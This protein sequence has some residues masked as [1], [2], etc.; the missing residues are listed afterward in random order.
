MKVIKEELI[1]F[2]KAMEDNNSNMKKID[3]ADTVVAVNP[4]YG[5]ALADEE[6]AKEAVEKVMKATAKATDG[7]TPKDPDTGKPLEKN[8][9]SKQ[10]K[11][12]DDE[13]E[14]D[15]SLDEAKGNVEALPDDVYTLVY[16]LIFHGNAASNTH[17]VPL[18]QEHR[19]SADKAYNRLDGYDI[20]AQI[21]NDEKQ[22]AEYIKKIAKRLGLETYEKKV[23]GGLKNG[24]YVLAVKIPDDIAE[25]SAEAF[26]KKNG[27]DKDDIRDTVRKKAKNPGKKKTSKKAIKESWEDFDSYEEIIDKYMLPNGEGDTLA[28][29]AVTAVNKLVYKWFNDGDVYDNT[30]RLEGWANDLSSYANWLY[31]YVDGTQDILDRITEARSREDYE[32][33]LKALCDEVLD[34]ELLTELAKAEKQDSIYEAEGPFK[35]EWHDDDDEEFDEGLKKGMNEAK[36]CKGKKCESKEILTLDD[37]DMDTKL[38]R[39]GSR[40]DRPLRSCDTV[41]D[42]LQ[43]LGGGMDDESSIE[44]STLDELNRYLK[45]YGFKPIG[46]KNESKKCNE[47]GESKNPK[48]EAEDKAYTELKNGLIPYLGY[49]EQLAKQFGISKDDA[50]Q[51]F[52][53]AVTRKTYGESK[54]CTGK[55]CGRDAINR[56]LVESWRGEEVLDDLIDRAK[57]W[58]DSG[59][60]DIEEAVERAIDDGL[61]YTQ[62]VIDLAD[63]YGVIDE[64]ELR[65]KM[66]DDVF[67][68]VYEAVKDYRSD[69]DEDEEVDESKKCEDGKCADK[70][71]PTVEALDSQEKFDAFLAKHPNANA[72]F[73]WQTFGEFF[74]DNGE[75]IKG[76][77]DA[78]EAKRK[79]VFGE[80][81]AVDES[82]EI[83]NFYPAG[84]KDSFVAT[85]DKFE[86]KSE[87]AKE[88]WQRIKD[89]GK[90]D[91]LDG[92]LEEIYPDG[93]DSED[94]EAIL[95]D[96][97]D[98]VF[99][100]LGI[101]AG[102]E[103]CGDAEVFER[104][105]DLDDYKD[106]RSGRKGNIGGIDRL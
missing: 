27:F 12:K 29:Q 33:I 101:E 102:I 96:E 5:K 6:K 69:E 49:I 42:F 58:I 14:L 37:V 87:R 61:I 7:V 17:V 47:E 28:S 68:D 60:D 50:R 2:A 67:S 79:E 103:E 63:H 4:V 71:C 39:D 1:D 93:L 73:D 26:L 91:E 13:I 3:G 44:V 20:G 56:K 57:G 104:L 75:L 18:D 72:S 21:L 40:S 43:E 76:K 34:D 23:S 62:D 31:K 92:V 41:G 83:F 8:I 48:K 32:G 66:Y 74:D 100:A 16:D 88:T 54:K 99:G 70:S 25:E 80:G 36:K 106:F 24:D 65:N 15:E 30:Y 97:S 82:A 22:E 95:A 94:L 78:W 52:K 84:S 46:V 55:K 105:D 19:I 11:V 77:M 38:E 89:A 53:N 10:D 64:D 90:I 86:P 35:F 59:Y 81:G 85:L 9:Y 98:M 51:A 45:K